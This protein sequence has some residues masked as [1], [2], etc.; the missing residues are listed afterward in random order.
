[1]G[2]GLAFPGTAIDIGETRVVYLT[3][4]IRI[5]VVDGSVTVVVH[6]VGAEEFPI[7]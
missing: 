2:A 4:A 6:A 1:M 7:E 3:T 5:A